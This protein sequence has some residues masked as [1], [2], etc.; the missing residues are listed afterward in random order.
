MIT[1]LLGLYGGLQTSLRFIIPVVVKHFMKRKRR[2]PSVTT[3][4]LT[5][6]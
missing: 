3:P 1:V 2:N 4:N 6:R 5:L